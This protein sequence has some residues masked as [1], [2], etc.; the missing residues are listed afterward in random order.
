MRLWDK[1]RGGQRPEDQFAKEMMNAL[2]RAGAPAPLKYDADR[3]AILVGDRQAELNLHNLFSEYRGTPPEGQAEAMRRFVRAF[4]ATFTHQPPKT[5]DEARPLLR[6][7]VRE[8][9]YREAL[10]LRMQIEG[11][12]RSEMLCR[13]LSEHLLVALAQDAPD[14]VWTLS[15]DALSAWEVG[16]DEAF[17]VARENLVKEGLALMRLSSGVYVSARG[18]SYD[19]SRLTLQHLIRQAE[20]KGQHVAMVPNRDTLLITGSEDEQGLTH[21][22]ACA[23]HALAKQ[24]RP[25]T[26]AAVRLEGDE[27]VAFM[28][29]PEHPA[30]RAFRK[31]LTES[32]SRNYAEQG[33]LLEALHG[34]TGEDVFVAACKEGTGGDAEDVVTYCIWPEGVDALLPQTDEVIFARGDPDK[35][36][37]SGPAKWEQVASAVGDLMVPAGMYPERFRAKQFPTEAQ[38]GG[39]KLQ[40]LRRL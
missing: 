26:G 38:L 4:A 37:F 40:R 32:V 27:W 36:E 3:F 12:E 13:P 29:P 25:M 28:P 9:F 8:R 1:L 16:A 35:P 14:N 6:P 23:E 39:M 2:R 24:P 34:K 33:E 19:A 18:D 17:A 30:H 5:F 22:A 31:L 10:R 7:Y 21:M 11:A 15:E 20:V